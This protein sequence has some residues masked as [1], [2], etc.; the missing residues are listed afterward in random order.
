MKEQDKQR[1]KLILLNPGPVN[2]SAR[3][4]NALLHTDICHREVEF[5]QLQKIIRFALLKVY[6]LSPEDYASVLLTGSGTLAIEAMLTSFVSDH[7]KLLILSNGVYGER[8]QKMAEY[9]RLTHTVLRQLWGEELDSQRI[10]SVLFEDKSITHIA[11]VHHETTTGRLNDLSMLGELCRKY[12]KELLVDAVSSFGAEELRFKEWNIAACAASANKC[13]HGAPGVSF[14]IA[15]KGY[16]RDSRVYSPR[17]VYMDLCEYY[18]K[19]EAG[20]TPFTAAVPAFFAFGEALAELEEEG[21]WRARKEHYERLAFLIRQRLKKIGIRQYLTQGLLSS[22]LTAFYLPGD[23]TYQELHDRLRQKQFVI[24]AG[25]GEISQTIF[26]IA[27]MGNLTED[28]IENLLVELE[29]IVCK[30]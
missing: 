29:A 18:Q 14:V 13:L 1:K 26:R 19:Q 21:G 25:Q 15:K 22:S 8:I 4:K 16:L 12:K 2:L 20:T 5:S 28:E 7:T 10:E 27:N 9:H 24:Y 23:I 11:V 17:S 30:R 6:G 3:V